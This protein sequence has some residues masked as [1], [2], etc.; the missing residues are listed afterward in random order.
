[1]I[2]LLWFNALSCF[3]HMFTEVGERKERESRLS[4]NM[5]QIPVS[6]SGSLKDCHFFTTGAGLASGQQYQID[7]SCSPPLLHLRLIEFGQISHGKKIPRRTKASCSAQR[8]LR[9]GTG[10]GVC[11]L[12]Q[13]C[14]EKKWEFM[15]GWGGE[16]LE[17][18]ESR[19][20]E[21]GQRLETE[22]VTVRKF[23]LNNVAVHAREVVLAKWHSGNTNALLHNSEEIR[24]L[25]NS[26]VWGKNTVDILV[27]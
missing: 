11:C 9:R 18:G 27:H 22:A 14:R 25:I 24:M 16:R 6:H 13:R 4:W 8:R 10:M 1:M 2:C 23:T 7:T 12:W 21:R 19:K 3:F 15:G 20:E 26:L 17:E 5:F